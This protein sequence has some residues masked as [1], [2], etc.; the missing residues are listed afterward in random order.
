M[1]A[2]T[3]KADNSWRSSNETWR[4]RLVPRGMTIHG[5]AGLVFELINR[6]EPP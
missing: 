6:L 5:T 1:T 3:P 2:V 4:T